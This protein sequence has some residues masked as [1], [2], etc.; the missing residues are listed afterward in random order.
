M[1]PFFT[2]LRSTPSWHMDRRQALQTAASIWGPNQARPGGAPVGFRQASMMPSVGLPFIDI[3]PQGAGACMTNLTSPFSA[4]GMRGARAQTHIQCDPI[5]G[6]P[7]WFKPAGRPLLWSGDLSA[8][9]RVRKVAARAR[10][11]KG[12]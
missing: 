5:T 2:P 11:A 6:R 4:G 8:C 1:K 7:V 10:R 9:K 3:V 12:R